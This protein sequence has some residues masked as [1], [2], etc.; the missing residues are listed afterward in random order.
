MK[1]HILFSFLLLFISANSM[2]KNFIINF[3][4]NHKNGEF[5]LNPHANDTLNFQ[6]LYK[7][8]YIKNVFIK[9]KVDNDIK[10]SISLIIEANDIED[11]YNKLSKIPFAIGNLTTPPGVQYL[12]EVWL[13]DLNNKN[14]TTSKKNNY[15]IRLS[16][17]NG[18]K[19]TEIS[20]ALTKD[21]QRM[22]FLN[23]SG[24]VKFSY[25]NSQKISSKLILPTFSLIISEENLGSVVKLVESFKLVFLKYAKVNIVELGEKI[26]DNRICNNLILSQTE[27]VGCDLH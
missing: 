4:V 27:M 8:K 5:S 15:N 17:K 20:D 12:G 6:K 23:E 10:K 7:K 24:K 13:T 25:V 9:T 26:T 2:A 1:R 22:V 16:W 3:D 21:L 11:A 14:N 19:P 18:V